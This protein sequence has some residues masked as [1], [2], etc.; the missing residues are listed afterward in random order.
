MK[1]ILQ[2]W[3]EKPVSPIL[4]FAAL[5]IF[6]IGAIIRMEAGGDTDSSAN[7]FSVITEHYGINSEEMERSITIPLEESISALWGIGQIRSVSE[8]SSS[9]IDIRLKDDSDRRQFYLELRD[10]V[11]RIYATMPKSV[12]KPRIVS[13]SSS[14]QPSFIIS[15]SSENSN[16]VQL[17]PFVEKHIKPRYEKIEG[18][19]E[20]EIGGGALRE[21]QIQVDEAKITHSGHNP[22]RIASL[23]QSQNMFSPQGNIKTQK[24]DIPVSL[25]GRLKNL[26]QLKKLPI[27]S[28]S[29]QSMELQ[30]M[31][32]ISFASREAQNISRV[33][34]DQKVTLYIKSG[35]KANMLSLS[36][37]IREET[38]YWQS[39]G[40]ISNI[41]Y[42]QGEKMALAIRELLFSM[43]IGM[44][45]V[46]VFISLTTGNLRQSIILSLSLPLSAAASG[47]ILTIFHVAIDTRILAGMAIAMG[48]IIDSGIII[49]ETLKKPGESIHSV[50]PPI[51][52]STLSSA[53]VLFPLLHSGDGGI[54][55]VSLS[56]LLMLLISLILNI[57]FIPVFF[58]NDGRKMFRIVF[59]ARAPLKNSFC[60]LAKIFF[61]N[62]RRKKRSL[63]GLNEHF[64]NA[65]V[66][67]KIKPETIMDFLE[68]PASIKRVCHSI[69]ICA[70]RH[71]R[72]VISIS[73]GLV[74][75]SLLILITGGSR[76][77]SI[78]S[79]NVIFAHSEMESAASLRSVDERL[80]QFI[81]I[82]L[83]HP[84]IMRVE[85][86]SRRGNGQLTIH[87]SDK[88]ERATLEAWIRQKA[89]IMPRTS[90]FIPGE[91]NQK[92]TRMEITITGTDN[93]TLRRIAKDTLKEL[94]NEPW[95]SEAVLHFKDA[96]PSYVLR[97]DQSRFPLTGLSSREIADRF[98]WHIQGP[99]ADKWLENGNEMDIRIMGKKQQ[100]RDLET[101]AALPFTSTKTPGISIRADQLGRFSTDSEASRIYRSNQQRSVYF[102]IQSPEVNLEK[103]SG[104]I[105]T[106]LERQQVPEGYAFKLDQNLYRHREKMRG[107]WILFV[108]ALFLVYAI[109]AGELESFHR[110]LSII[111]FIPVSLA[112]PIIALKAIG[113]V[114][115]TSSIVGFI[116]LSGM[117]VNNAILILE[118][119]RNIRAKAAHERVLKAISTRLKTLLLTSGTTIL[120]T[121]P[122]LLSSRGDFS[123]FNALAFIMLFGILGSLYA[124]LVF[125]P[126]FVRL[127]SGGID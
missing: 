91:S 11:E 42:D 66:A 31:A 29:G 35:G 107:L 115:S 79:D 96:P 125:L 87:Y 38:A 121:V 117:V 84:H 65:E 82:L 99:V 41:V 27:N 74:V 92:T 13:S 24:A 57:V 1:H 102:S 2:N 26:D 19:G 30:D 36:K 40:L 3:Y 15:F 59:P 71:P 94:L 12:Q 17:R 62:S 126:A 78:Q 21:V 105:W 51:I 77:D 122:L 116:A 88:T 61:V 6:C 100:V 68:V 101:L 85:T 109:L 23:I 86:I 39:Q 47:G 119:C 110:P 14:Q 69:S 111:L 16:P 28:L 106:V 20:I 25:D 60:I 44:I 34:G 97:V 8:Y 95:V 48:M 67:E 52:S 53:I 4:A 58:K 7:S 55:P 118:E 104:R 124:S 56:L 75:L 76:F 81:P 49:C 63:A 80:V 32:H 108:F 43:G 18:A 50:L 5:V 37:K 22:G 64:D 83:R 120:G 98:R 10:R 103:L 90:L 93:G 114:L 127:W 45:I 73:T 46:A 113:Q 72:M 33:Q 54:A 9:R 89:P 123:F 112:F 70:S